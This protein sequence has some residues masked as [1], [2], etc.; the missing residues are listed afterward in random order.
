VKVV[1][2]P[3]AFIGKPAVCVVH[4]SVTVSFSVFPFSVV[5]E[6][7][8]LGVGFSSAF[9]KPIPPLAIAPNY[10]FPVLPTVSVV[11]VV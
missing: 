6:G 11:L 8:V 4:L 1:V 7:P 9:L 2:F 5:L 10:P 3:A